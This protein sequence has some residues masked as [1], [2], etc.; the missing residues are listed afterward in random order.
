MTRV[1][2]F[3]VSSI[4]L[5]FSDISLVHR[6]FLVQRTPEYANKDLGQV[7]EQILGQVFDQIWGQV[8]DQVFDQILGQ[9]FDQGF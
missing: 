2:V 6:V 7:F 1:Y 4:F 5:G 3:F 8:F 9:V